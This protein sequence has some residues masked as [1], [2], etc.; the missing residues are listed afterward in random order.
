M[1]PHP[2]KV[3][4]NRN[5]LRRPLTTGKFRRRHDARLRRLRHEQL[6]TRLLLAADPPEMLRDINVEIPGSGPTEIVKVGDKIFVSAD[7]GVHGHELFVSDG[8]SPPSLVKDIQSG[9]SGSN[10][11]HLTDVDGVLYFVADDGIHGRELWKSDGTKSGTMLVHDIFPGMSAYGSI[12]SSNPDQ[13]T[14]ANTASGA[15]LFFVADSPGKGVELWKADSSGASLVVDLNSGIDA[16]DNPRHSS[17]RDLTFWPEHTDDESNL[18]PPTL[19]FSAETETLG[20]EL[21]RT[22]VNEGS[23][24]TSLVKNLYV[25]SP[26]EDPMS[27]NPGSLILF[28][29]NLYFAASGGEDDGE[30]NIVSDGRELWRSDGTATGTELFADILPGFSDPQ[31]QMPLN[32]S[33]LHLTEHKGS[34]YFAALGPSTGNELWRTDGESLPTLVSNIRGGSGSSTPADLTSTDGFLFFTANGGQGKELWRTDGTAIGTQL[35]RDIRPGSGSPFLFTRG[36]EALGSSVIFGADDGSLGPEVWISDGTADGTQMLKE[37]QFGRNSAVTPSAFSNIDGEVYFEVSGELWRTDGSAAGTNRFPLDTPATVDAFEDSFTDIGPPTFAMANGLFFFA[38]DDGVNGVE[39]WK[40]DGTTEGTAMVRDLAP[41]TTITFPGSVI[42]TPNSSSPQEIT[43]VGDKV[44]FRVDEDSQLMISDGTEVGTVPL[45][46]VSA[47]HL[48][49]FS[50]KLIFA[51]QTAGSGTELWTSDGTEQGTVMLAELAPANLSS[52]PSQFTEAGGKLFFVA[53][54]GDGDELWVTDGT[55]EGTR[56]L[57]VAPTG[58]SYPTHLTAVDGRVFFRADD[59]IHGDELWVSD[60]TLSGTTMVADLRTEPEIYFGS[61][62]IPLAGLDGNLLFFADEGFNGQVLWKTDGTSDGTVV[63]KDIWPS[64]DYDYE[65]FGNEIDGGAAGLVAVFDNKVFFPAN[66]G[67]S[68]TELWSSDGTAEGTTMVRELFPGENDSWPAEL[69]VVGDRLFFV[70]TEGSATPDE[71]GVHE[72]MGRELWSTDGTSDGTAVYAE[73][74]TT[75]GDGS[76]PQSLA[77]FGGA[78]YFVASDGIHGREVWTTSRRLKAND[79][80]FETLARDI[81]YRDALSGTTAIMEEDSI[82]LAAVGYTSPFVFDVSLVIHDDST[83]FDAYGLTAANTDPIL[84]IRGSAGLDDVFSDLSPDGIGVNQYDANKDQ[85]FQ[86]ITANSSPNHPVSITGHSLGG[87]LTQLVAAGYTSLGKPLGQVVTFN[88]PGIGQAAADSFNPMLAERVM[89]YITDGDPVSLAGEAFLPGAWRRSNFD[90]LWI[91]HNHQYPVLLDFTINDDPETTTI[92]EK[93]FRAPDLTFTDY[94][95]TSWLNN[96]LYFHTDLDYFIWLAAAQLATNHLE[97]LQSFS[98]IPGRL[99]FRSTTEAERQR[100]GAAILQWQEEIEATIDTLTCASTDSRIEGPDFE[101]NL[102]N[103]LQVQATEL[104]AICDAGPPKQLRLQ[105]KVVLPQLNN[106]TADFSGDNYIGLNEQGFDL[107]GRL[108]VDELPIVPGFWTLRDLFVDIDTVD[109]TILAGGTLTIPTGIEVQ[110]EVGF[111]DGSFNSL[112]LETPSASNPDTLNKP[113]GSTGIFLQRIA[114]AVNHVADT[115]PM[116]VSFEGYLQATGGP[117]VT[118]SLPSWAGGTFSGRLVEFDVNGVLDRNHLDTSGV[119]TLANGLATVD[120]GVVLDWNQGYLEADGDLN[121]LDGLITATGNFRADSDLDIHVVSNATFGVPDV[122]PLIG[123]TDA[124]SG[125]FVLDYSNDSSSF[126][127]FVAAWTTFTIPLL[128]SLQ[129][130]FRVYLDGS[131]GIIGAAE[132][133]EIV[134]PPPVGEGEQAVGASFSIPTGTPWTLLSAQWDDGAV[135]RTIVL[136]S[137][138]GETITEADL[139]GRSDIAIVDDLSDPMRR[140]VVVTTPEAGQWTVSVSDDADLVNLQFNA[141]IENSLPTVDVVALSGGDRG[142]P[143]EITFDAIDVDSTA[144]VSLFY[145]TDG[146][147]FDGIRVVHDLIEAD[148]RQ[149]YSWQPASLPAAEYFIY[150]AIDDGINPVQLVYA[151]QSIQLTPGP[152]LA[153]VYLPVAGGVFEVLDNGGDFVVRRQGGEELFRAAQND[154]LGVDV[155]GVINANDD[156]I[157]YFDGLSIPIKFDGGGNGFNV[158]TFAGAGHSLD[159]TQSPQIDLSNIDMIDLAGGG[160]DTLTINAD[161]V[162][163]IAPNSGTIRLRHD[164]GDVVHYGD[165]WKVQ[166]PIFVQGQQYHVMTNGSARI[167]THNTLAFQNPFAVTDVNFSGD[168]TPLD[169]LH[170]INL[171]GRSATGAVDLAD[172]TSATELPKYYYD[173]DGNQTATPLDALMVINFIARMLVGEGESAAIVTDN[174]R[175]AESMLAPLSGP[176]NVSDERVS[177]MTGLAAALPD[178]NVNRSNPLPQFTP[179]DDAS[180]LSDRNVI[181]QNEDDDDEHH[182]VVWQLALHELLSDLDLD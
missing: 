165:G 23:T 41:G 155:F 22:V 88:A 73:L 144:N 181:I 96:P 122:I 173:V 44:F 110:A 83:G 75:N 32:S 68:G 80:L 60:G 29:G 18:I 146:Q 141:F 112:S 158:L 109:D 34:L 40:S 163:S 168:T 47:E 125:D 116:P 53:D 162:L 2:S 27:S 136:T 95:D 91:V 79:L 11:S 56:K 105:G 76:E 139:A 178:A 108:S 66:D 102:L 69:T 7:D 151:P 77:A 21:W 143:V 72:S 31:Q 43:A 138:S 124:V 51:G 150:A 36:Y 97:D 131:Y 134:S 57:N 4:A 64:I 78:L 176:T 17:P 149:S 100:V 164:V 65:F 99:I 121:V 167:E 101:L 90:D 159:L 14:V 12:H 92:V 130:G 82:N 156:V 153:T 137:P 113:L 24:T 3:A 126:N 84:V 30:G 26:G 8:I 147:G 89:H 174:L 132:I 93:R 6:E 20:R 120:G 115:D 157:T 175:P 152:H 61:D 98:D 160:Q 42:E 45:G 177:A 5:G 103:V 128:G 140:V 87:A 118:L 71:F 171:L 169:A 142:A 63:V 106:A 148:G 37:I 180:G 145:D 58:G 104:A 16:S 111:V 170:V 1:K 28:N 15:L 50:G 10:P 166:K 182:D 33:P 52:Y 123:G 59:G 119:L 38:A 46:N 154:L 114:G 179:S 67:T 62:P 9:F 70:A 133:N 48:T 172:P 129:L 55:Q 81:A 74:N 86:W 54:E 13:L 135:D 35:T 85:L 19:Y 161:A 127:D 25:D 39:L 49:N 117:S 107:V 94:P